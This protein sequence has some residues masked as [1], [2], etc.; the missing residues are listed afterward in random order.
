MNDCGIGLMKIAATNVVLVVST[1]NPDIYLKRTEFDFGLS[2]K[3]SVNTMFAEALALTP[4]ILLLD[5][6][7]KSN[8]L[9]TIKDV[10]DF[11]ANE[12]SYFTLSD[13]EGVLC[14]GSEAE[15]SNPH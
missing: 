9:L 10:L 1:A 14:P 4:N 11:E 15:D 7:Q 2:A 12:D 3:E 5:F 8:K 13:E 6:V